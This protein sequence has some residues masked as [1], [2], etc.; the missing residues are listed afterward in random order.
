MNW[1][2]YIG[3]WMVLWFICNAI[4]R[5]TIEAP[6]HVFYFWSTIP[7]T[8]IWIWICWRFIA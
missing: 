2:I 5:V 7:I 6:D 8:L 3:G 1:L 4:M